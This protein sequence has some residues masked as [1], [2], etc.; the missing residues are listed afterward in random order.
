MYKLVIREGIICDMNK[1]I[2]TVNLVTI[3]YITCER[4]YSSVS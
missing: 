4:Y 1:L 3:Q 2:S